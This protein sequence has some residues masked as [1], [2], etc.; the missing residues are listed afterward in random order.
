MSTH[1]LSSLAADEAPRFFSLASAAF[2]L[3]ISLVSLV[4]SLSFQI[5]W[6][7]SIHSQCRD[8]LSDIV[9]WWREKANLSFDWWF[10]YFFWGKVK[11]KH[12]VYFPHIAWWA[13]IF[14]DYWF[15][16]ESLI[17]SFP[18]IIII[19]L[20]IRFNTDQST[21]SKVPLYYIRQ[22]WLAW[23]NLNSKFE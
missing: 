1:H 3:A 22:V 23:L 4:A 10:E 14:S 18:S 19:I 8:R 2:D 20:L 21:V 13:V 15:Y 17:P 12:W 5:E 9:G 11:E 7:S 16:K 6:T